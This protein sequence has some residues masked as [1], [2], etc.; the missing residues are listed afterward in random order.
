MLF[1]FFFLK[2]QKQQQRGLK[3][4]FLLNYIKFFDKIIFSRSVLVQMY[5]IMGIP[6]KSKIYYF[7]RPSVVYTPKLTIIIIS[8]DGVKRLQVKNWNDDLHFYCKV[9]KIEYKIFYRISL[10]KRIVVKRHFQFILI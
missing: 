3:L 1:Y 10:K 7:I 9:F 8:Y 5:N 2:E 4:L 6:Y